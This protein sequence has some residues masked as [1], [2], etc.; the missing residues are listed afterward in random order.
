LA[1]PDGYL[2]VLDGQSGEPIPLA[3]HASFS[4]VAAG[5]HTLTLQGL[6]PT[7][8]VDG[9]NPRALTV[10][11]NATSTVLLTVTCAPAAPGGTL[12][13][14]VFTDSASGEI[15]VLDAVGGQVLLL[16]RKVGN[17]RYPTW[18]PDG[19]ALVFY[20]T[21]T[22]LSSPA[23]IVLMD[24]SGGAVT[25]ITPD[26]M[27]ARSPAWSPDGSVIAFA[28]PGRP[29]GIFLIRPDGSGLT[30]IASE[31][32]VYGEPAWSA[33]G[34]RIAFSRLGDHDSDIYV[35]DSDGSN[36]VRIT[37]SPADDGSPSWSPDGQR[38]AFESTR[39]AGPGLFVMR[40]DGSDVRSLGVIGGDPQWSP[41]GSRIAFVRDLQVFVMNADGTNAVQVTL[42][43]GGAADP[44][45]KP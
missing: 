29:G 14:T 8:V 32:G 35:V 12:A 31:S 26:T 5:Q 40:R 9:E 7:C 6:A 37:S 36:P 15:G 11:A 23:R 1:D 24:A 16:S 38:I 34:K 21:S 3:G 17:D 27:S 25:P 39:V 44:V 45:W 22:N 13:V 4:G 28:R 20:S 43:P 2:V 10:P 19:S 42:E 33:D 41:D 30:Q 18:S